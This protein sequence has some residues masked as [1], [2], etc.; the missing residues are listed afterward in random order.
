MTQPQQLP[1]LALLDRLVRALQAT[2]HVR[3][4]FLRGSFAG[5]RPDTYSRLDLLVVADEGEPETLLTM[6]REAL[7][8]S[9]RALWISTPDPGLA[10]LRALF[11]GPIRL[12]LAIVTPEALPAHAG[13]RALFDYDQLLDGRVAAR[14]RAEPLLPEHVLQHCDEFWWNLFSSVG[15]LKREQLWMALHVL[16]DCRAGLAQIMRW[17]RDP[18]RP[19][20]HFADLER[21]LSAEDQQALAQTLAGYDLR[22]IAQAL[23]C[24][25]DA[26]DPAAREVAARVGAE[27]PSALAHSVKEFFIREFWS[28]LAPGTTIS[29]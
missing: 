21:H 7:S 16:G 10:R 14:A 25:A 28:L 13:W 1:Q 15:Q 9:G 17:R 5:G 11:P 3:A 20:E 6:G 27:Y 4:A 26:F 22:E 12:D 24:A 23:L 2:Q 29:A 8:A 18:A 19:F